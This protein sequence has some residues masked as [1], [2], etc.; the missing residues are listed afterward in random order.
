IPERLGRR[1]GGMRL[2]YA[3]EEELLG[4]LGPLAA[5]AGV[6]GESAPFRR[7]NGDSLCQWPLRSVVAAHRKA[8]A[9][10]TLLLASRA[11]AGEFGGG[12][13]VDSKGRILGFRGGEPEGTARRGVFAGLHVVSAALLAG[14]EVRPSD[15]V[16]DLYEPLIARG[17]DIRAVFTRRRWHDLGTPARYLEG[18]L[19]EARFSFVAG[20]IGLSWR[21]E[22]TRVGARA[23]VRSTVMEAGSAV[24]PAARVERSLL[25]A[26][27]RAGR[28][29][30]VRD[31]ILG[32]GVVLAPQS[33]LEGRLVT[34]RTPGV[35]PRPQDSV[36]GDLV[37]SPMEP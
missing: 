35:S 22:G 24:A 2:E 15:V 23:R 29:S 14:L 18:V 9:D 31:S 19:D 5:A 17:A 3:F 6:L 32:P 1:V 21:G 36:V 25:M 34:R 10:A 16:R 27:A 12:V 20:R 11:D 28:G 26:K 13:T 33:R 8:S 7:V 37:Y 4:T 30:V